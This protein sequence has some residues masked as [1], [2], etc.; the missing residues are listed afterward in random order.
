MIPIFL[1]LV[2]V[3]ILMFVFFTDWLPK[4]E[5]PYDWVPALGSFIVGGINLFYVIFRG[6][7]MPTL[8]GTSIFL[9]VNAVLVVLAY[10]M[11]QKEPCIVNGKLERVE[12][13]TCEQKTCPA[14]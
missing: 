3:S 2:N 10:F 13:N 1:L 14:A 8:I 11:P 7:P 4:K 5:M 9:V 6:L 12:M